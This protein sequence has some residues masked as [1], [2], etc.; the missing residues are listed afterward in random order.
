MRIYCKNKFFFESVHIIWRNYSTYRICLV[1]L[2][3]DSFFLPPFSTFPST[4]YFYRITVYFNTRI[5][6]ISIRKSIR[7]YLSFWRNLFLIFFRIILL[8]RCVLFSVF[9][10]FFLFSF[11]FLIYLTLNNMS[12]CFVIFHETLYE[13][14]L[15][16]LTS[17][18]EDGPLI[19][20]WIA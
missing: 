8:F 6:C 19:E 1:F 13:M 14:N 5:S 17:F 2:S 3:F 20:V 9:L 15:K 4:S 10:F 16:R 7:M 18:N 12:R 11:F